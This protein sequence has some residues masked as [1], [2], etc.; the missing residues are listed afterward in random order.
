MQKPRPKPKPN[1]I[2][3]AKF[4]V[5]N[6]VREHETEVE[7]TI[8]VPVTVRYTMTGKNVAATREDPPEGLVVEVQAFAG[9]WQMLHP[10]CNLET[11]KSIREAFV[12]I[13]DSV[14][15]D[16]FEAEAGREEAAR[17]ERGEEP[18]FHPHEHF[19]TEEDNLDYGNEDHPVLPEPCQPNPPGTWA[20]GMVRPKIV[21][22]DKHEPDQESDE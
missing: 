10:Q 14:I 19:V 9:H 2:I 21:T 13:Q 1:N 6:N 20:K 7:I 12:K 16:I 3:P 15:D 17:A 18:I 22:D 11:A 8:S 5:K 4:K